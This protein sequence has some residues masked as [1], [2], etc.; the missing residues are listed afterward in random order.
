MGIK[1]KNSFSKK[2]NRPGGLGSSFNENNIQLD[3]GGDFD[4]MANDPTFLKRN[5]PDQTLGGTFKDRQFVDEGTAFVLGQN[6]H[7]INV[8][9]AGG[10]GLGSQAQQILSMPGKDPNMEAKN[11]IKKNGSKRFMDEIAPHIYRNGNGILNTKQLDQFMKAEQQKFKDMKAGDELLDLGFKISDVNKYLY[12]EKRAREQ[13]G[14]VIPTTK[15]E[16]KL[17]YKKKKLENNQKR[18]LS[19]PEKFKKSV[20][21]E[22]LKLAKENPI[23]DVMSSNDYMI[24]GQIVNSENYN[25]ILGDIAL[26]KVN[27]AESVMRNLFPE[28]YQTKQQVSQQI[29]QNFGN[30]P[31]VGQKITNKNG[32]EGVIVRYNGNVPVIA[33]V[34]SPESKMLQ[35]KT[36]MKR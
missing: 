24:E 15:E 12:M 22:V 18:E 33:R 20:Q 26:K 9:R 5:I 32:V 3:V 36:R 10:V 25:Q 35:E 19:Y 17:L 2:R 34:G 4:S 30:R 7:D 6:K 13:G 28:Q 1:N 29:D 31:E 16:F 11:F 23:E 8:A 14:E 21:K 27:Q